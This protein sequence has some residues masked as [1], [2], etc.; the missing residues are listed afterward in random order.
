MS[1]PVRASVF[2]GV[3]LDGFIARPDGAFDFLPENPEP[4]GYEEFYASV[5]A[6]VMGRK[7]YET[8]RGFGSWPYG[9]KPVFVLSNRP[10]GPTPE[11]AVIER[12]SGTPQEIMA[13]LAKR[14]VRHVYVDGGQTVQAFL[15]AGV[16]DQMTIT[17]VPVLI[18][19]GISIFGPLTRDIP[20]RHIATRQYP[21]GLVQSEYTVLPS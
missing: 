9:S 16:I 18:G 14:G 13:Q 3:S 20:L 10:L 8:A 17:R 15:R 1:T 19:S 4:H 5:D 7:T 2:V 21:S 6:L 12:L 11:G